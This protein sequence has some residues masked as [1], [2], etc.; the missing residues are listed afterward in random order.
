MKW[1]PAGGQRC[2]QS[3]GILDWKS[4]SEEAEQQRNEIEIFGLDHV[5]T[6]KACLGNSG[7]QTLTSRIFI[8]VLQMNEAGSNSLTCHMFYR[9]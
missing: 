2:L 5:G 9:K 6:V 3:L 1:G 8:N 7:A 4:G